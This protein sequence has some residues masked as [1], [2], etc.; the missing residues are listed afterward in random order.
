MLKIFYLF[1]FL[2]SSL[3]FNS[4]V[5][6][7]SDEVIILDE[8]GEPTDE[9]DSDS[10]DGENSS[11]TDEEES[12][13]AEEASE[14]KEEPKET[15]TKEEIVAAAQKE[16]TEVQKK[17]QPEIK[18]IIKKYVTKLVNTFDDISKKQ[19]RKLIKSKTKKGK[20]FKTKEDLIQF[21]KKRLDK[22]ENINKKTKIRNKFKKLLVKQ[23]SLSDEDAEK[24][25][26]AA[27]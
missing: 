24:A 20:Q 4:F 22:V 18:A 17:I 3:P 10:T 6:A 19:A 14:E 12:E 21:A 15:R 25:L 9:E 5:A 26:P 1:I 23:F 8:S 2:L 13:S 27:E 16:I 7:K 11:S